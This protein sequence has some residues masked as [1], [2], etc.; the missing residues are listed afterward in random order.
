MDVVETDNEPDVLDQ[1]QAVETYEQKR[2]RKKAEE[3]VQHRIEFIQGLRDM[4]DFLEERPDLI[5]RYDAFD[6]NSYFDEKQL[7]EFKE[8][9]KLL[10]TAKKEAGQYSSYFKLYKE[11]GPH[12]IS[13]NMNR[14][15]VCVKTVTGTR[16]VEATEDRIIPGKPA[17][18]EATYSWEC[19]P[20]I[21]GLEPVEEGN[22]ENNEDEWQPGI[23]I[24][25]TTNED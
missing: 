14:E 25:V 13:V 21:L 8:R 18:M 12:T 3:L 9:A 20:S 16:M 11:F 22:E 24:V 23:D 17:H 6:L 2:D 1:L 5:E 19:P 10:G 4:A 15:A 7:N